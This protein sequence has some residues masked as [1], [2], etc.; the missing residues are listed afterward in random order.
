MTPEKILMILTHVQGEIALL[1]LHKEKATLDYLK[2][3]SEELV[4]LAAEVLDLAPLEQAT[5]HIGEGH[6]NDGTG[7][8]LCGAD[9]PGNDEN[10]S[11]R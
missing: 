9:G 6:G 3:V 1:A 2:H 4:E 5:K 11:R 10:W 7:H 8:C